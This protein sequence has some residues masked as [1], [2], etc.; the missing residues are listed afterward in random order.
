MD[1]RMPVMNGIEAT[2][3]IRALSRADAKTVPIIAMTADAFAEEQKRH[4]CHWFTVDDLMYLKR[5]GRISATTAV[6]GTTQA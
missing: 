6:L 5:G 1:V 4:Q 3:A 2:R